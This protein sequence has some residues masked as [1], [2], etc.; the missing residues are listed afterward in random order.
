ML[1]ILLASAVVAYL[2]ARGVANQAYDYSLLDTAGTIAARIHAVGAGS[3]Q[4]ALSPGVREVLEYDP[5][6]KVYYGVDSA[7]YGLLAGRGDLPLPDRMPSADGTYYDGV[8]DGHQVRLFALPLDDSLRVIVA[9]TLNKRQTLTRQILGALLLSEALLI[10]V[11][12]ALLWYGIGR[13]MAPLRRIVDAL[14]LRGQHD[15]RPVDPGPAPAELRYLAQA[16]NELMARLDQLLSA[17]HRFI[18]DTA[19]QLRTPLAG[20]LAQIDGAAMEQD[21]KIIHAT[22]ERLQTTSKRAARLVNQLLTLARAEPGQQSQVDFEQIDL[23]ELVRTTCKYWVPEALSRGMDLGFIGAG[24]QIPIEGNPPLLEEMLGNL[25]ENA[26][27]YGKH[28]GAIDVSIET[29]ADGQIVLGVRNEGAA[30]PENERERIF[31]R[32]YR[33]DGTAGNGCG[34]GLAIVRDVAHMHGGVVELHT[35]EGVNDFRIAFRAHVETR[36]AS[37]RNIC[38]VSDEIVS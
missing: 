9:E 17:Q 18:A 23:T 12:G 16:I 30:I 7:R 26:I 8:I 19:H 15:L 2:I 33:I 20:L 13:G 11:G 4:I 32:F 37:D 14:A 31:E 25:I 3:P 21:P 10:A 24:A 27:R 1:V 36:R 5:L 28:G 38:I 35:D 22:F 29:L 34:L 6:D